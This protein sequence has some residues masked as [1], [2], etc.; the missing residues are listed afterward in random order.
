[1]V[2]PYRP[3]GVVWRR[4]GV[5]KPT[6][7]IRANH[8]G[9]YSYRLCKYTPGVNV[10]EECFQ[11][12]PLDFVAN[13]SRMVWKNGTSLAFSP[14]LLSVGTTPPGSMWAMNPLPGT[15]QAYDPPC[16]GHTPVRAPTAYLR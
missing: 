5:A 16:P 8:G 10:T 3:T 1:M 4:G 15:L 14:T 9:G 11:K 13:G 2:L 7:F 12:T 6:W